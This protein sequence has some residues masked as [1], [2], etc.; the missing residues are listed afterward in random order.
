MA[1]ADKKTGW[2]IQCVC[3][4]WTPLKVNSNGRFYLDHHGCHGGTYHARLGQDISDV[5][6]IEALGLHKVRKVDMAHSLRNETK[7]A[8][9]E[10]EAVPLRNDETKPSVETKGDLDV[11]NREQEPGNPFALRW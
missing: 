7:A 5:T 1:A 6:D 11:R 3:G 9:E 4:N 8:G 10:G 2:D